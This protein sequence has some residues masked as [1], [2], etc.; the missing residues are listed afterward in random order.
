MKIYNLTEWNTKDLTTL[1]KA[2]LK[3]KG[4]DHTKYA[5][6]VTYSKAKRIKN[7]DDTWIGSDG[8]ALHG[9]AYYQPMWAV[10]VEGKWLHLRN[11]SFVRMFVSKEKFDL[12]RFAQIFE[13]EV[14]HTLGLRHKDMI[15]SDRL[16]PTWHTN[17][18]LT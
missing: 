5:V 16:E 12:K 3:A 10:K 15:D 17:L 8:L 6:A 14:D 11:K 1:L 2:G 18:T 13:H 4:V 9:Y 7:R